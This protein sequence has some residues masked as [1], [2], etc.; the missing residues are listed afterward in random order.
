MLLG[1]HWVFHAEKFIFLIKI[2]LICIIYLT[3][4][5]TLTYNASSTDNTTA[6]QRVQ[7]GN[8]F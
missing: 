7:Q 6:K 8:N 4:D 2:K 5:Q 3:N 1:F